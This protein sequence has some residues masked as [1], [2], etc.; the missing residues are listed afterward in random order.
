MLLVTDAPEVASLGD[1][2][3]IENATFSKSCSAIPG[4]PRITQYKWTRDGN[5][6]VQQQTLTISKISRINA[7]TYRC[8]ATNDMRPTGEQAEE[9]SDSKT[10]SLIVH[11]K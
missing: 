10:F 3:A 2:T 7:G 9:G 6:V 1:E 8:M 4:N 11:C 5:T